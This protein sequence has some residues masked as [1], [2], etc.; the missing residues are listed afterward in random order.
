MKVTEI[1]K[2]QKYNAIVNKK[3]VVVEIT[4][5][6][7][8]GKDKKFTAK[9]IST[10]RGVTLTAD[11]IESQY[12]ETVEI[13]RV[14]G[15]GTITVPVPE[16]RPPHWTDAMKA[17]W[18][19]K[20][21]KNITPEDA[22]ALLDV[23]NVNRP[24][25][26]QKIE[27]YKQ[28]ILDGKFAD[29]TVVDPNRM[30]EGQHMKAAREALG[31]EDKESLPPTNVD[32]AV[33]P[34]T[35]QDTAPLTATAWTE[36]KKTL[37]QD[38]PNVAGSTP[39]VT[40]PTSKPTAFGNYVNQQQ[41]KTQWAGDLA[42]HLII[43]ARAGTG[44]TTTLVSALRVLKG[45]DPGISPSPQQKMVWDYVKQSQ[46]HKFTCF[47]AFNV[48]IVA[49]LKERVPAGVDCKTMH[50]M[51]YGAIRRNFKLLDGDKAVSND[52]VS[53]IISELYQRDIRELRKEIP[54][55]IGALKSLVS[56][57]KM[58]LV[59]PDE[60]TIRGEEV[61]H[62]EVERLARHYDI[63]VGGYYGNPPDEKPVLPEVARMIPL[64]MARC[65]EVDKD[66]YV[67]NDDQI[68][69]PVVLNLP[70]FRFDVLF[71]DECQDLNRCQHE[72]IKKAGHRLILC[73]DP[74][75]AIYGF[76]GA[77][78]ES[79]KRLEAELKATRKGCKKLMLTVTRRCG[80]K[81]VD[82]ARRYVPEFD[83]HA[84]NAEGEVKEMMY[85]LQPNGYKKEPRSL[86]VDKTYV[87]HVEP[88]DMV[89]CRTVAPLVSQYFKFLKLG[90]R[91][92]IL[93]KN[94]G[95]S[96]VSLVT[97][98]KATDI[99]ELVGKLDN[100]LNEETTK[101]NAK[102]NP[103]ESYLVGL[104]DRYDTIM[105]FTE[106]AKNVQ[107][108]INKINEAF[109][110]PPGEKYIRMSSIHK[111]KGLESDRVFYLM[112]AVY[113]GRRADKMPA[114]QWEQE[115][116]LKYVAITRAKKELVYVT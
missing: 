64:V 107:E 31:K 109:Q 60:F 44:K 51:G 85:P 24:L 27:E 45:M 108:V 4:G 92:A 18:A 10:G 103:S 94:V 41:N 26:P 16:D 40:A 90:K 53:N 74:H 80:K 43:E 72:L 106:E 1:K 7:G 76:A 23:S 19:E 50:S 96:L 42:P 56:K 75:Q 8:K 30:W 100:W 87:P 99:P 29:G 110:I 82:E 54:A 68:W 105:C 114:W 62:E 102:R 112:P 71:V 12:V 35:K 2:G 46:W 77:D 15:S 88:G 78:C 28:A 83:A 32:V 84:D 34:P 55:V 66:K 101:E 9:N 6:E 115:L 91:A 89:V 52:R 36:P 21:A 57:C 13:P 69:I 67:D 38:V 3:Q 113:P 111:A 58:N 47:V 63:D 17:E 14:N 25:N 81:I 116:N 33:S 37:V 97:K 73:G 20:E 5:A 95:D 93:G 11:R 65:L 104:H 22:K 79:M 39:T 98:M 61:W 86:E 48:S 59:N 70:M 49:E